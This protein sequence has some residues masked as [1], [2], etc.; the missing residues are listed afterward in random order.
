MEIL[1]IS[2]NYSPRRGGIEYLISNLCMDLRKRHSVSIVNPTP[3]L[4]QTKMYFE[5]HAPDWFRL[6][7]M[8]FGAV[9]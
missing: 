1:V 2:W 9:R 5:L 7:S 8:R 6:R 4:I 3:H